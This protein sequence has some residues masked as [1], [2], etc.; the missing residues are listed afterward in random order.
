MV[1]ELIQSLQFGFDGSIGE[2]ALTM[3]RIALG[4]FFAI[5]G[6]HKLFNSQRHASVVAT[7]KACN[8]PFIG[9][10]Q[11][12]VPSVEF[13]GGL[14]LISGILSPLA[15]FGL[16]A[17]CLVATITDGLSRIP[18]YQPID[19]AD[20]LDDLLYLP[21]VLYIVGLLVVISH[22]G[23]TLVSLVL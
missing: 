1:S 15:A 7:L 10:C 16:I 9:F 5:S 14:S 13:L 2:V 6:Y 3:N 21:E 17:I 22:P 18:G 8:I 4:T 12:F 11:W 19:K 20:W 23:Y